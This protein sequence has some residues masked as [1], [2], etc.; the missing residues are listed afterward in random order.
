MN[1]TKNFEGVKKMDMPTPCPDC[2][3]WCEYDY[4]KIVGNEMYCKSCGEDREANLE[5]KNI[6]Y[7]KA[8]EEA[9]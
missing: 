3:E 7:R 5:V 9:L 6:K 1:I 8:I 4:M 2:G